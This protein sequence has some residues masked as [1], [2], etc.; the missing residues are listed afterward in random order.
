LKSAQ[1]SDLMKICTVVAKLFHANRYNEQIVAFCNFASV[2]KN[3][4]FLRAEEVCSSA[5][6]TVTVNET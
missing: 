2:R 4:G 3:A 5:Y 1:I 6:S